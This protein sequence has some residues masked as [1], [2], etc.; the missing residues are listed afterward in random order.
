MMLGRWVL[1]FHSYGI[2]VDALTHSSKL[3]GNV[4]GRPLGTYMTYGFVLFLWNKNYC[5]LKST[6][7]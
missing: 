7:K 6:L 4:Y 5:G 2:Q 1:S 3:R